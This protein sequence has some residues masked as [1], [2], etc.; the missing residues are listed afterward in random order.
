MVERFV[1][2]WGAAK[3]ELGVPEGEA[4]A[5]DAHLGRL[6]LVSGWGFRR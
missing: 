3:G 5:I 4:A 2:V 6:P 1:E